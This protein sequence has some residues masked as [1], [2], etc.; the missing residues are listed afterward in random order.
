MSHINTNIPELRD[1][2]SGTV[3]ANLERLTA[4]QCELD[5]V[6]VAHLFELADAICYDFDNDKDT[7]ESILLSLRETSEDETPFDRL[8]ELAATDVTR[9]LAL[10]ERIC[11]YR[12]II[13]R[14][15][16]TAP[17]LPTQAPESLSYDAIGRIA[18]MKSNVAGKA[19][20][21]VSSYIENCRATE[22][23]SLEDVCSK[24]S[25]GQCE[26]G[27]LPIESSEGG[28]L[29]SILR[30][31]EK[32]DLKIAAVCDVS[33]RSGIDSPKTRFAL[34][35]RSMSR[36]EGGGLLGCIGSADDLLFDTS[37]TYRLELIHRAEPDAPL[38]FTD[39]LIAARAC[40]LRLL[41]ADTSGAALEDYYDGHYNGL[42][43]N[44]VFDISS[45]DLIT[46]LW[47]IALEAPADTV[48]GIYK[49]LSDAPIR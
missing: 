24:V 14:M 45:S 12:R 30:L 7:V 22:F 15:R 34:L 13:W 18:Y 31:I 39:M 17:S 19:Y 40:G 21:K 35:R 46:F 1:Y 2:D 3:L 5:E 38:G 25:S 6:R 47:Y 36:P 23:Y 37:G 33:V 49:E 9:H 32:Y 16:S 4:R 10:Q 48:L 29:Q 11:I 8:R 44:T 41:R 26:Y 20:L 27:L 43:I 42:G 28:R